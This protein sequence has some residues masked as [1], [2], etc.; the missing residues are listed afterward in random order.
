MWV[1]TRCA[2]EL[3]RAARSPAAS[4]GQTLVAGWVRRATVGARHESRCRAAR[5]CGGRS[6]DGQA[7][8]SPGPRAGAGG[9][10]L[11][12][13]TSWRTGP[14]SRS[15][16]CSSI[17]RFRVARLLETRTGTRAW[18]GSRSACPA[19]W[20]PALSAELAS[21]FDLRHAFVYNFGDDSDSSLR[22]RLGRGAPERR[23]PTWP[24]DTRRGRHR[25]V[26][27]PVGPGA[28]PWTNFPPLS[29]RAA[30]RCT[31]AAGRRRPAGPRLASGDPG[32]GES[33]PT[34]STR[35]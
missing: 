21:A 33:R 20:T 11:P 25:L 31:V 35:R 13:C 30:D 22:H 10:E 8:P 28:Q 6:P 26:P 4:P 19:P 2:P 23:S 15:P 5:R 7:V 24:S 18:C 34:A 32:W 29:D 9:V 16:A 14:R 17:S 1:C 27:I 12:G 3:R